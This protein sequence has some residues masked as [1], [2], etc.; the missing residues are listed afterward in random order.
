MFILAKKSLL[1]YWQAFHSLRLASSCSP[2]AMTSFSS[3]KA[4]LKHVD[5]EER[6]TLSFVLKNDDLGLERQFNLQRPIQETF[7][8]F[9]NRINSNVDKVRDL[10]K[11]QHI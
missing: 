9:V 1:R 10:Y 8:A 3:P 7:A 4:V 6:F 5:G 2:L 11:E